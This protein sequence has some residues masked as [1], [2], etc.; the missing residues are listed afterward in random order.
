MK[1]EIFARGPISCA[2]YAHS[3]AF[4][5]YHGNLSKIFILFKKKYLRWNH[6]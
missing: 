3:D 6:Y 1:A 5:N 4:E 2:L